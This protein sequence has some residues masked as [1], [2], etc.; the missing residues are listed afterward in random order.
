MPSTLLA[1]GLLVLVTNSINLNNM[2]TADHKAVSDIAYFLDADTNKAYWAARMPLDDHT[3]NYINENIKKGNT[4]EFFPVLNWEV[5]YAE[6]DSYNLE[7]PSVNVV[8]DH[9]YGD[10]R[11]I[12]YHIQTNRKASEMMM[13]SLTPMNISEL[14]I[15]GKEVTL[16][17]SEYTK[18]DAFL[19]NYVVGL[20]GEMN[21]KITV[22]AK[23][24]IKWIVAD[25]SNSIPE[26]KGKMP[27]QYSTFGDLSFVMRTVQN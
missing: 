1:A 7:G 14:L 27:S 6:A 22:D 25:R 26:S 18:D 2:P 19:M 11:T 20:A 3:S 24:S 21:V 23:D 17:R 12:E 13:K 15:N 5:S 4:S 8:S 9:V 16:N 10:K